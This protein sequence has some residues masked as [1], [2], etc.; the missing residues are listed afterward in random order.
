MCLLRM[1]VDPM[2]RPQPLGNILFITNQWSLSLFPAETFWA[3]CMSVF[4]WSTKVPRPFDKSWSFH[5]IWKGP[6]EDNQLCV[7]MFTV[8]YLMYSYIAREVLCL[9]ISI[10]QDINKKIKESSLSDECFELREKYSG[11]S[12]VH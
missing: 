8:F 1:E 10:L 6:D 11:W 5:F 2:Q 4:V 7:C 12:F 9:E 3:N